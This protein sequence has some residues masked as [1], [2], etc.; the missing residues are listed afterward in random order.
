MRISKILAIIAAVATGLCATAQSGHDLQD[1]ELHGTV[2]RIDAVMYEAE[3]LLFAEGGFGVSPI[4]Y[5]T[6]SYCLSK[7]VKNAASSTLGFY[8]FTQAAR[9]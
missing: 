6:N 1:D 7:D 2:K 9:G 8:L 3:G 5:Y 4:Y